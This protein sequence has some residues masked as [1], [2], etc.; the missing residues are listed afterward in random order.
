[1]SVKLCILGSGSKGNCALVATETTRVLVDAGLSRKETH[2]RLGAIGEP[3]DRFDAIVIS[4]EHSDHLRGLPLLAVDWPALYG[5]LTDN[6]PERSVLQWRV[7]ATNCAAEHAD[8][9][10][11]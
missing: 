2:A 1:M 5:R 7:E 9:Q 3:A 8:M 11:R 4:H 10:L 6:E